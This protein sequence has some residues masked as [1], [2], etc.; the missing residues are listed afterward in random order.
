MGLFAVDTS[1]FTENKKDST[2]NIG[3]VN[4]DNIIALDE[5][6]ILFQDDNTY[7]LIYYNLIENK[8]SLGNI[9][10]VLSMN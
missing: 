4:Y 10:D 5:K 9:D 8:S 7:E 6:N 3:I 2:Y 1:N